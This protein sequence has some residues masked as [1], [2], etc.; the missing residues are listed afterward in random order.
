MAAG[1][2]FFSR[3]SGDILSL[4]GLYS[5]PYCYAAANGAEVL[6]ISERVFNDPG[7]RFLETA[8]FLLDVMAP[9]AFEARGKGIRS[10]QKV[11]LI[12]AAIRHHIKKTGKW[13]QD[14]G[15]PIN[16]EDMAG[17]N[18]AFSFIILRGLRKIGRIFSSEEAS[19]YMHLWNVIGSILGVEESLLPDTSKEAYIIDK[20]ISQRQ[21][22]SSAAGKKLTESLL[23]Y[24]ISASPSEKLEQSISGYMRYLL[25]KEVSDILDIPTE[26]LP[27]SVLKSIKNWNNFSSTIGLNE[28]NVYKAQHL[29]NLQRKKLSGSKANASAFK[30][31][32]GLNYQ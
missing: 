28:G 27:E 13:N 18:Q 31:P 29:I 7:K 15:I 14:W 22:K 10:S 12:H 8:E 23:H 21:F 19:A 4:L 20:M 1:A 17:T 30:I 24:I 25:G 2:D 11:R 6:V 26:E 16:Q 5:L 32:Q 3:H 9:N